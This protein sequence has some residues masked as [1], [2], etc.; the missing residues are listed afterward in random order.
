M[1]SISLPPPPPAKLNPPSPPCCAAIQASISMRSRDA[2]AAQRE[3]S[4]RR[5]VDLLGDRAV[6]ADAALQRAD[7]VVATEAA[8]RRPRRPERRG[9]SAPASRCPGTPRS[10]HTRAGSSPRERRPPGCGPPPPVR[11]PPTRR[12]ADWTQRR[13]SSRTHRHGVGRRAGRTLCPAHPPRAPAARAGT[14][15]ST[16]TQQAARTAGTAAPSKVRHAT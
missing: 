5:P 11:A 4:E 14:T 10:A 1:S 7:E 9:S 6:S 2:V 8:G 12:T 3:H 16:A 15:A 13:G